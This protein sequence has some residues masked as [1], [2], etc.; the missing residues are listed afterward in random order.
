MCSSDLIFNLPVSSP[1]AEA[2]EVKDFYSGDL[3]LYKD[4]V[5]PKGW[6][7]KDVRKFLEKEFKVQSEIK[8]ILRRDPPYFTSN[9]APF[10]SGF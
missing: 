2:L 7:R 10:F 8:R 5:H 6:Q 1:E 4:F 3:S 9:H